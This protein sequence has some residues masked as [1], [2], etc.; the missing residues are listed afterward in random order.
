VLNVLQRCTIYSFG[1]YCGPYPSTVPTFNH[2]EVQAAGGFIYIALVSLIPDLMKEES[3]MPWWRDVLHVASGVGDTCGALS[4]SVSLYLA[5]TSTGVRMCV[6]A[7]PL[8][9]R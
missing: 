9:V 5:H 7:L 4:C 3:S 6:G 2:F 8:C 1:D